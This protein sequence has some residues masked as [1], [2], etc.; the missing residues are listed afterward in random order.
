M[1]SLAA[2]QVTLLNCQELALVLGSRQ[3]KHFGSNQPVKNRRLSASAVLHKL[4]QSTRA[5]EGEAAA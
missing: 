4:L 2:R 5:T 3:R 1:V